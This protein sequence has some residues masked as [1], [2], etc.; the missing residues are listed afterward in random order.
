LCNEEVRKTEI[1]HQNYSKKIIESEADKRHIQNEIQILQSV[2]HP[3][4][5]KFI[6]FIDDPEYYC[7]VMELCQGNSLLDYINESECLNED[8]TQ[9]IFG[10]LIDAI[11]FLHKNG[12]SYRDIKPENIIIAPDLS[13]KL[14][15]F[16]L[17]SLKSSL[18]STF[19]GSIY[20][21]AP[22]C[23]AETPYHGSSADMW[24]LGV[25]LYAMITGDLPWA[26]PNPSSVINSILECDY[27]IPSTVPE[28][29]SALIS[30][31]LNV[32]PSLRITAEEVKCHPWIASYFSQKEILSEK[33]QSVELSNLSEKEVMCQNYQKKELNIQKKLKN[34]V[35]LPIP[36]LKQIRYIPV[37]SQLS[38]YPQRLNPNN[39]TQMNVRLRLSSNKSKLNYRKGNRVFS[40]L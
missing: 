6:E 39:T 33:S 8:Q 35:N 23:L 15:D 37:I 18:L 13:V 27:K 26:H 3:K 10:Q 1:L 34:D 12:I 19:C 14:I 17:S 5:V 38:K 9:N 24:S 31:L 28:K 7:L 30:S 21:T 16:G 2:R 25:V 4:I 20:Y 32:D 40:L 11:A 22:E 29:I 36:K